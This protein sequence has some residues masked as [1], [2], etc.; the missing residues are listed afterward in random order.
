MVTRASFARRADGSASTVAVWAAM[1]VVYVVWGS[2]YLAMRIAD[3]TIPPLLGA[4][5]RFLVAGGGLLGW[6][7]LRRGWSALRVSGKNLV[8]ATAVG[9]A[10][11]AGGNA[12]VMLAEVHV[13]SGLAALL[14]ASEPMM[15]VLLRLLASDRVSRVTTA[16]L[17]VGLVGVAIL[18]V[19][20]SSGNSN[21]SWL[22]IVLGA[23]LAWAIGSYA[24][25]RLELPSDALV[26]TG[27]QM[28]AG[29]VVIAL[30]AAAAGEL[31]KVDMAAFSLSSMAAIA[32]LAIFGSLV[33]FTAYAWLLRN[34]PISQVST[35][36][37]VNPVIAV[38][39]GWAIAGEALTAGILIGA[40]IIVSSVALIVRE[41]GKDHAREDPAPHA[42][43]HLDERETPAA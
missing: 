24:S 42:P 28:V 11:L 35:Y 1:I 33:A 4:A 2:T 26:S 10:L 36:A 16:A 14:I 12:V 41:E 37:Y 43:A 38:F 3:E 39:L 29:G 30:L 34:A 8:A 20:G 7:V 5:V 17:V 21:I 22:L 13:A 25:T 32:Y 27:I 31:G 19:P 9:I 40:A 15:I 18:V 23:S 6:I